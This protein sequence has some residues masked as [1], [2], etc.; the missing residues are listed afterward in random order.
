VVVPIGVALVLLG[1][2]A[3]FAPLTGPYFAYG[4][5]THTAWLASTRQWELSIG[6]GG[7]AMFAGLLMLVPL[8]PIGW[9]AGLLAAIAGIWL[10]IGASLYP[11]WA[12]AVAPTG[13]TDMRALKWIGYFYGTGAVIVFLA[14]FALGLLSRGSRIVEVARDVPAY[15]APP[16]EDIP[17][18]QAS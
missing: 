16:A 3:G 13:S 6:P 10:V 5:D 11:L 14:A 2:W 18:R 7:V 8:R 4:F 1:A 12:T 9:L 17:M 15:E